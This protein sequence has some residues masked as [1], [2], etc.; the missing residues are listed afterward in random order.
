MTDESLNSCREYISAIFTDYYLF[1]SI[2]GEFSEEDQIQLDKFMKELALDTKVTVKDGEFSTISLSDGQKK[3]LAL[4]VSY[5]E[6]RDMYLFDEWAADQDPMF[7]ETFYHQILPK[8]KA[9]GKAVLV[10]S[11]DDRYFD[12]ADRVITLEEGKIKSIMNNKGEHLTIL[13]NVV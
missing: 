10:I 1:N 12:I 7:K 8:L 2:L 9:Q 4:L 13:E 5:I 3:R 6:N 11:H